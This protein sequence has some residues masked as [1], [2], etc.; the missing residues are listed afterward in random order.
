MICTDINVSH[1]I[2]RQILYHLKMPKLPVN[3]LKVRYTLKVLF[4]LRDPQKR[5]GSLR[6]SVTKGDVVQLE[7]QWNKLDR[8]EQASLKAK[9]EFAVKTEYSPLH[10]A[11]DRQKEE[12]T[13]F[14][15][16]GTT[17][18]SFNTTKQPKKVKYFFSFLRKRV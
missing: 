10:H 11:V 15:L 1:V 12:C 13:K 17:I 9:T 14:L 3:H 18:C 4:S 6:D 8:E 2:A 7:L 5:F 16:V